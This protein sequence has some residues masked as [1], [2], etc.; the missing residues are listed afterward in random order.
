MCS[1]DLLSMNRQVQ[2]TSQTHLG[3]NLSGSK[4]D[5]RAF[6]RVGVAS[7]VASLPLWNA[8]PAHA[9]DASAPTVSTPPLPIVDARFPCR[10]ADGIWIIPDKRTPLVPNIG[11][12]E[13]SKAVLVID[14]G[15]TLESGRNVFDA[16]RA[17]AG[18]RD[19]ILTVTHAHPEHTFGAQ[20]FQGHARI[21]YNKLQRDYLARN[22]E[23]L[24][25]GFRTMLPPGRGS[26][27]DGVKVTLADDV[28]EG[29]H[30]SLDL[31][32][33]QV[34]FWTLGIAHSPGDQVITIPD[35]KVTF[36]GDLIEE[37]MFPIVPFFPPLIE[38]ADI[39]VRTWQTA[40]TKIS[41]QSPHIV[42]PGHGNLGGTEI[43]DQVRTYLENTRK[44]VAA[45]GGG[46][47]VGTDTPS[48]LE[49]QVREEHPT[50]ERTEFIAPA[51]RYFE[52]QPGA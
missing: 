52:E 6:L 11:I 35:Q 24:L 9:A 7:T 25:A 15:F 44:L 22:G 42:V 18:H 43:A 50:W 38:V 39:D 26:L 33:R 23:K 14:A 10:I 37:R 27:L 17:I 30:A 31:G 13:G 16:A 41:A 51:L 49:R 2:H 48:N 5:R 21:Y 47:G 34:E 45:S 20:A 4:L 46:K 28:Y 36:A 3:E 8:T 40:L 19:L 1:T 32:G 29:G 12:I